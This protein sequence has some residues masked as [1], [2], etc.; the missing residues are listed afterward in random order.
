MFNGIVLS[1]FRRSSVRNVGS[2][3]FNFNFISLSA[4]FQ[5]LY[6]TLPY[7]R[8]RPNPRTLITLGLYVRGIEIGFKSHQKG[9]S[10]DNTS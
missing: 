6:V 1:S 4:D 2:F 8:A 7:I 9:R 3:Q 5:R 10:C